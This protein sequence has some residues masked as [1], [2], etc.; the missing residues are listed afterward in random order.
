M[1]EYGRKNT[2]KML[3]INQRVVVKTDIKHRIQKKKIYI[4][5]LCVWVGGWMCVWVCGV[6]GWVGVGGMQVRFD[7]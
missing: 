7:K 6:G 3:H 2:V 4:Y 1:K 5:F